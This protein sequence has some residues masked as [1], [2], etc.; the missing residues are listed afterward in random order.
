MRKLY[1][2]LTQKMAKAEDKDAER[3]RMEA[4]F[5][6]GCA[7]TGGGEGPKPPKMLD[8]D[9]VEEIIGGSNT[10]GVLMKPGETPFNN[11]TLQAKKFVKPDNFI[12]DRE[13][14]TEKYLEEM[15]Q[16]EGHRFMDEMDILNAEVIVETEPVEA[17]N[18]FVSELIQYDVGE[19]IEAVTVPENVSFVAN[20]TTSSP[21]INVSQNVLDKPVCTNR[22]PKSH[23][24][25]SSQ[26]DREEQAKVKS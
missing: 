19:N 13:E 15:V 26:G 23:K 20:C 3:R 5:K 25:K 16:P 7:V 11:V 17:N 10:G 4:A 2:Q 1:Q 21:S 24:K 12:K 6:K 8:G 22:T 14:S 18:M 9:E